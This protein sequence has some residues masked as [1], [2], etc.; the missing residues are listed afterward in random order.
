MCIHK[1]SIVWIGYWNIHECL[2]A[3]TSDGPVWETDWGDLKPQNDQIS[4]YRLPTDRISIGSSVDQFYKSKVNN[5]K[6]TFAYYIRSS[7]RNFSFY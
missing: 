2:V 4:S 5:T 3:W 7:Q 6:H 1:S